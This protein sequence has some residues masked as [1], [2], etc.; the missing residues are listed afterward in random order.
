MRPRPWPQL[1][2]ERA[3]MLAQAQGDL[4][5]ARAMAEGVAVQVAIHVLVSHQRVGA[6]DCTCGAQLGLGSSYAAHQVAALVEAG[7][8]LG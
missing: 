6:R 4:A 5:R 8:R 2:V 7:V 3:G 1:G